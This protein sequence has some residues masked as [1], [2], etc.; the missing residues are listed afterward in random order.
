MEYGRRNH[1][2]ITLTFDTSSAAGLAKLNAFKA[3]LW[4]SSRK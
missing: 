1:M 3:F 2:K 4:L